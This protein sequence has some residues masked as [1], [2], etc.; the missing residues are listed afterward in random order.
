M[1][2]WQDISITEHETEQV[3]CDCC[4]KTTIRGSG[5]LTDGA[6]FLGWYDLSF[7]EDM[8]DH[9]PLLSIYVGDWSESGAPEKRWGM[10]VVWHSEGC[11]L[12]DWEEGET[13]GIEN[14]TP[15]GREAVLGTGF[16]SELWAMT[17]AII[18]K[19]S[20]LERFHQT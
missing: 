17:D 18:M 12:L 4:R 11:Q 2:D 3:L 20:R 10:R 5:E 7:G 13:T 6:E 8:P 16:E 15:L 9:P 1:T 14:Y 19:D